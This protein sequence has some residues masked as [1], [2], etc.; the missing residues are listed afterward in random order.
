[1]CSNNQLNGMKFPRTF[2]P[3]FIE[4]LKGAEV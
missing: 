4:I 3:E 2:E 1:M